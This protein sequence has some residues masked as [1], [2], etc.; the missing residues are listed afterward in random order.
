MRQKWYFADLDE[1]VD[2]EFMRVSHFS[3]YEGFSSEHLRKQ[4]ISYA[5]KNTR[6]RTHIRECMSLPKGTLQRLLRGPPL[7]SRTESNLQEQASFLDGLLREVVEMLEGFEMEPL[8]WTDT[9]A[10]I[11]GIIHM[12]A[13]ETGLQSKRALLLYSIYSEP[14]LQKRF[15]ESDP[16]LMGDLMN[17]VF[18]LVTPVMLRNCGQ[19]PDAFAAALSVLVELW[20][21]TSFKFKDDW[22]LEDRER[23]RG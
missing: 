7:S 2:E 8:S 14:S 22:K 18:P 19:R 15:A 6:A 10:E 21:S 5:N 16:E 13:T 9:K 1:V 12:P 3:S 20:P 23:G 11:V 17:R 4:Q